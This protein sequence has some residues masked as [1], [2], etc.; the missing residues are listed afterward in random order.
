MLLT[1]DLQSTALN[2]SAISNTNISFYTKNTGPSG[3][4]IRTSECWYQKPTPFHLAIPEGPLKYIRIYLSISPKTISKVPIIVTTSATKC[5]FDK[6][7]NACKCAKPGVRILHLYGL[8]VPS[9]TK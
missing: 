6:K 7:S 1:I 5:F 8:F 3:R 4:R 9:A 2:H